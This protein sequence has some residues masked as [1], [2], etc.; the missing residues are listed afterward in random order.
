[1]PHSSRDV[2][3][4]VLFA[5]R[6]ASNQTKIRHQH[7][8]KLAKFLGAKAAAAQAGRGSGLTQDEMLKLWKGIFYCFWMADKVGGGKIKS[9]QKPG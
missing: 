3:I 5:Q 4:E 8:K 7:V 2:S 6:L 1:M 9:V